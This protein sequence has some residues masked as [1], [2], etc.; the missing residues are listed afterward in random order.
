MSFNRFKSLYLRITFVK[1]FRHNFKRWLKVKKWSNYKLLFTNF[2][3]NTL[4]SFNFSTF[5]SV[6]YS[7]L[8]TGYCYSNFTRT[9]CFIRQHYFPNRYIWQYC[10]L[11][12]CLS[13]KILQTRTIH[14]QKLK[15]IQCNRRAH[16][17]I[18]FFVGIVAVLIFSYLW[19]WSLVGIQQLFFFFNALNLQLFI[20]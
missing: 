18:F 19:N 9:L 3:H 10:N 16:N 2:N 20:L 5:F 6:Q 7:I 12:K 4:S 14:I 1:Y 8:L 13:T 17:D 15:A 11:F